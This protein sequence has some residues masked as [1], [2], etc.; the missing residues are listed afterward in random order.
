MP[1]EIM[2]MLERLRIRVHPTGEESEQSFWRY[3][4]LRDEWSRSFEVIVIEREEGPP[5]GLMAL[6]GVEDSHLIDGWSDWIVPIFAPSPFSPL[7]FV[8]NL[9]SGAWTKDLYLG[10]GP[11]ENLSWRKIWRYSIRAD[12]MGALCYLE[13]DPR[14]GRAVNI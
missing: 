8:D 1:N 13:F 12:N 7:Y 3:P 4:D 14:T 9:F 2:Y 11:S 5:S 6:I 10:E